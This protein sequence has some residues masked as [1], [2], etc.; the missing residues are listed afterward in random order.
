MSSQQETHSRWDTVAVDEPMPLVRRQKIIG[1]NA[2]ISR[3]EL[4]QGCEVPAHQHENEQFA[5]VLSGRIRFLVGSP[6][7][8]QREVIVSGGEVLHLPANLMH[9]AHVLADAV[10][11]DVFSPPSE[12]TGVDGST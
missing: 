3:F 9:S 12:T 1:S 11:L 2:M 5:M 10:V 6:E 4:G 7:D 8:G